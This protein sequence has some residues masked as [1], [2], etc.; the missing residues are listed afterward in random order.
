MSMYNMMHG[1]NPAS[2]I[3]LAM[4]G[5]KKE[6]TG[7]FR[8]VFLNEEGTEISVFTRNGGGNRDTYQEV[9]DKLAQH[10]NYIKDFDD[11]FDCT[12]ATIV[13]KTPEKALS[14]TKKMATGITPKTLLEK[15]QEVLK[16]ME[17]MSKE[18]FESDPRFSPLVRAINKLN[19]L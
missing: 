3:L 19:N 11:D 17:G 5:L 9:I 16:E 18:Q 4:L 8:D 14:L 10:P 7:R 2:D 15:T 13:F 12:Y 1:V 6:D